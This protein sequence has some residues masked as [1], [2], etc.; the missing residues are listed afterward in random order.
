V[1]YGR[2][3]CL[4]REFRNLRKKDNTLIF[5]YRKYLPT[6]SVFIIFLDVLTFFWF[7]IEKDAPEC[8]K[9]LFRIEER[10][11]PKIVVIRRGAIGVPGNRE[12]WD[13]E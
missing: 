1:I 2:S 11:G 9:I 4:P 6:A 10:I 3:F 8:M 12:G 5:L 13:N 7:K